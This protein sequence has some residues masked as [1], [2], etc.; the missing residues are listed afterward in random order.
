VNL[1]TATRL[2]WGAV[3]VVAG[4][5]AVIGVLWARHEFA[6]PPPIK[7][8]SEDYNRQQERREQVF[9]Q[10]RRQEQAQERERTVR[11]TPLYS[12]PVSL[13]PPMPPVPEQP[14]YQPVND[15]QA[16]VQLAIDNM[17]LARKQFDMALQEA[18]LNRSGGHGC[19]AN[20]QEAATHIREMESITA[21][22]PPEYQQRAALMV[23]RAWVDLLNDR[24][25][26]ESGN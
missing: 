21:S 1:G 2:N 17:N 3:I 14:T 25:A 9:V 15:P 24:R 13:P 26:A 12:A 20:W 4:G 11:S 23:K 5:V 22:L 6:E 18:R 7:M 10:R 16:A 8:T 19:S